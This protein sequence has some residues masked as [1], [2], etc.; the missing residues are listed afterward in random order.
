MVRFKLR[1]F[2]MSVGV[3]LGVATLV[4]MR[5]YGDGAEQE[6]MEKVNRM[7]S[8]SS[9]YLQSGRGG[10]AGDPDK[11]ATTLTLEDLQA[12]QDQLDAILAVDPLLV[13]S[14]DVSS[15]GVSR[16]TPIWANGES[17]ELVWGRGVILGAFFSRSEI[18][19]ASKVAL[20]G[21]KTARRF[22]G[23]SDPIGQQ[24]QIGGSA[25][26]VKGVLEPIGT[27]PHGMDRDDEIHIPI[28]TMMR[29]VMNVDYIAGAKFLVKD[30]GLMKEVEAGIHAILKERHVIR[31][32]EDK[33]YALIT[34]DVVQYMVGRMNR[35]F[36]VFLPAAACAIL[37]AAS[38]VIALIMLTAVKE[39]IQ[40]IGLRKAVGAED[41]GIAAQFIFESLSI[42]LTS[43][44]LGILLGL[45]VMLV[46][47]RL[48][49]LSVVIS[50]GAILLGL[51]AAVL[52][53]LMAGYL[54]ARKAAAM[55]PVDALR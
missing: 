6:M 39:R 21:D 44:V 40:E 47:T 9:L 36:K 8:A 52:A 22:F 27:D 31:D 17:G 18:A 28:S 14:R 41:G 42:T 20:I 49:G 55:N 15:G 32:D 2:F 24:L 3:V 16:S 29:R 51:V 43:G 12:I 33:D 1:T 38:M 19:Q 54:P 45:A 7:F 35:V 23:E 53:G 50:P 11:P 34:P 46:M 10:M 37:L 5:S 4:V 26:R 48:L 30:E 25:F 13:T